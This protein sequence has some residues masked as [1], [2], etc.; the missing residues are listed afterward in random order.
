MSINRLFRQTCN[1]CGSAEIHW[2]DARGL[3]A[4]RPRKTVREGIQVLG[5]SAESWYCGRCTNFGIFG[6]LEYEF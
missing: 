4:V 2:T 6:P 1:E 3:L 5:A